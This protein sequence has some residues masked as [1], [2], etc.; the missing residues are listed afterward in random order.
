MAKGQSRDKIG[1][2]CTECKSFNYVSEKN[3]INSPEAL[4]LDKYCRVCKKVTTH[5]ET[6]DLD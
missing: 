2:V 5:K 6:K 1:F 3:K 4:K